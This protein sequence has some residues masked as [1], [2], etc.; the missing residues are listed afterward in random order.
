MK[1]FEGGIYVGFEK[2]TRNRDGWEEE[3][4]RRVKRVFRDYY[5]GLGNSQLDLKG[6]EESLR[7]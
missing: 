1:D 3:L 7:D 5:F 6:K 4:I 2:M